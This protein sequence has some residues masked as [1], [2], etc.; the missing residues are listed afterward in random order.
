MVH[1]QSVSS[2]HTGKVFSFTLYCFCCLPSLTFFPL[3]NLK[4]KKWCFFPPILGLHFLI[5]KIFDG[6][7]MNVFHSEYEN[8]VA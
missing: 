6:L 1:P 3:K 8:L 2:Q 7:L 5:V 4:K